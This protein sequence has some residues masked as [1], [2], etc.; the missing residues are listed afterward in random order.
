MMRVPDTDDDLNGPNEHK[1]VQ[2]FHVVFKALALLAYLFG[3]LFT[4]AGFV[5]LFV[6]CVLLLSFDFWTVKNVSG[7]ILVGLRWWNEIRDDGSNVWVFESRPAN[8]QIHPA[9]SRVF[10]TALYVAPLLWGLFAL[11][12]LFSFNFKWLL[13]VVV[14]LVLN[15]ANLVGYWKCERDA[16]NKL[17]AFIAQRI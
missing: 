15:G 17:Q 7:R 3:N 16:K 4:S 9:D 14:G 12:A 1:T 8:R 5:V 13:V 2:F 6:T 11:G 10:W